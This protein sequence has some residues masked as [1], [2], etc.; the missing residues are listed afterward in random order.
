MQG[1]SEINI[2]TTSLQLLAI[3]TV[4]IKERHPRV[5][6]HYPGRPA[7]PSLQSVPNQG[8]NRCLVSNGIDT[9]SELFPGSVVA[10]VHRNLPII[11]SS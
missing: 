8:R 4:I 6:S 3:A 7:L 1:L 11:L 2:R 5:R 9:V 10:S